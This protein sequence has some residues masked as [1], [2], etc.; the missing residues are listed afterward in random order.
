MHTDDPLAPTPDF[1][2]RLRR[3]RDLADRGEFHAA[4]GVFRTLVTEAREGHPG[5][6]A[7]ALASLTTLYGRAGR[8]LEAHTLSARL[9]TLARSA[10]PAADRTLAHALSRMC[11]AL[12]LNASSTT[13]ILR[14][15]TA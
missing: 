8:Y 2:A 7:R 3:G 11:G 13:M 14:S 12:L 6:H 10:G 4:E 5:N 9:V 15:L 1:E